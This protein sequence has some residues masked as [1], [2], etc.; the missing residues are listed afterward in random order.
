MKNIKSAK[1]AF[2]AVLL[3][4]FSGAACNEILENVEPSTSVSGEVALTSPAGVNALRSSMYSKIRE[5]FG[6][7]TDY[8]VGPSAFTDELFI[9]P[10]ASR[11]NNYNQAIGTSGTVHM[12]KWN[13]SYN[14]IQDAN[15]LIGA[16][17]DGVLPAE[18]LNRFRGE[19]YAIRAFVYHTLVRDYGYEPGNFNQGPEANW[20]LGVVIRTEPVIDV[21]DADLRPRSTV[22]QVYQQIYSDLQQARS[23]LAGVNS[24]NTF[25]TE[26]FVDG[27]EARARLYAGDWSGA[28]TA[29]QNAISNFPGSLQNTSGSV[30]GMFF[31]S[32]GGG[33]HP[34]ALFKIVVNPD[35][36]ASTG[37]GTFVN[38]GPAG[39]T[40]DQWVSQLPTNLLIG[41]Y[42]AGDYRLG[43][44]APCGAAQRIGAPASGCTDV[45]T[46]GW[47][48]TKFNGVKGNA[49]D[50]LPYMRLAE[51]YLIWAE[52]AAKAANNPN[53]A[54]PPLTTL[55]NARNAGATPASFADMEEMEDFILDERMRELAVEG[56]R[57]YDL[58]R[59]GRD[60]R[61]P[62][63]NL[64]M[65]ANSYR[66]LAPIGATLRN[67]NELLEENP[68]Y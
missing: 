20:D 62:N 48:I 21:A 40:S 5:A 25:A 65:A 67:V 27:I 39:Y 54:I 45:N 30:A 24:N 17:G 4:A 49:V 8:F 1:Y 37:G 64:K 41:K 50:D 6:Y 16:I 47:S 18:T 19:A 7:T 11:F 55:R 2:V 43:W 34:E 14:I 31:E 10:G 29:A 32:G 42:E 12:G 23:L 53:A 28:A 36:E 57:F 15:L 60:I 22:D 46:Q 51:M 38:N 13:N 68:G 44:Y 35:T 52:A 66:I 33:N 56:H 9:R 3:L 58:K 61:F 26:A 63:G 59:L